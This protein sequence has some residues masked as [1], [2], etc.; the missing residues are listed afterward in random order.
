MKQLEESII[1]ERI[2]KRVAEELPNGGIVNLGVGIPTLAV[3]YL[4]PDKKLFI[5]TEN[6]MLG[7]GPSPKTPEETNP[8]MIN[9]SRQLITAI[10]GASCFDAA[11][12][13]AMIRGG[14]LDA[15]VIGALEVGQNGDLA[16][17]RIPGKDILGPGGAM[18]LVAGV[19]E[20]IVATQHTNRD[21][22]GKIVPRC[23]LPLTALSAI[24]CLITEYALFRFVKEDKEKKLVLME[25][26]SDISLEELKEITPAEYEVSPDLVVREVH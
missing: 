6:G 2:A 5:Q 9:A 1:K 12:S 19:K 7:V 14:R 18:D 8:N 24:D 3:D 25:H 26:S 15:T 10:P 16:N 20:V 23:T 4:P 17:W 22:K 11:T 13:F 21:G